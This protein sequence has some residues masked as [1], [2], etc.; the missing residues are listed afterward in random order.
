MDFIKEI[1]GNMLDNEEDTTEDRMS[2]VE[3]L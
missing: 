2:K 3:A 1:S